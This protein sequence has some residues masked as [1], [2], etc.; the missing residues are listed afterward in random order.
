MGEIFKTLSQ[1]GNTTLSVAAA[2]LLVGTLF[3]FGPINMYIGNSSELWFPLSAVLPAIIIFSLLLFLVLVALG[4][5]LPVR[6]GRFFIALVFGLGIA[7]YIEGTFMPMDYGI[8]DGKAVEWGK[9]ADRVIIDSIIWSLCIVLPFL[10]AIFK[11]NLFKK[12]L[13]KVCIIVILMQ[14]VGIATFL[15]SMSKKA[16]SN[17][18]TDEKKFTL[19]KGENIVV[20]VLDCFD[21]RM[22]ERSIKKNGELADSFKDFTYYENSMSG[23]NYTKSAIPSLLTGIVYDNCIPFDEYINSAYEKMPLLK[24]LFNKGYDSR[25]F[26]Y[27]FEVPINNEKTN[28]FIANINYKIF[29]QNKISLANLMCQLTLMRQAPISLKKIF[30]L[31]YNA[32]EMAKSKKLNFSNYGKSMNA[33]LAFYKQLKQDGLTLIEG[34]AF[35]F[36]HFQG[37]HDFITMDSNLNMVKDVKNYDLARLDQAEGSLK[38][39]A[40]FLQHI[41]NAGVY[42][43]STIIIVGDHGTISDPT[44]AYHIAPIVMIKNKH[45]NFVSIKKSS[46]PV[47]NSDVAATIMDIIQ[48]G[49]NYDERSMYKI[50]ENANRMRRFY[51]YNG[52]ASAKKGYLPDM[53]EFI[54]KNQT[55]LPADFKKSGKI[56]SSKGVLNHKFNYYKIGEPIQSEDVTM[57]WDQKKSEKKIYGERALIGNKDYHSGDAFK[58]AGVYSTLGF[59][60]SEINRELPVTMVAASVFEKDD[61][62]RLFIE[63]NGTRLK[64]EFLFN[65]GNFEMIKFNIPK[66]L[67]KEDKILN[68]KLLTPDA[69]QIRNSFESMIYFEEALVIKLLVIGEAHPADKI[70]FGVQE[71][72][73]A[74]FYKGKGWYGNEEK[75]TW[76]SEKGELFLP[77]NPDKDATLDFQLV[78][79]HGQNYVNINI[80]GYDLGYWNEEIRGNSAWQY[81]KKMLLPQRFLAKDGMNKLVLTMPTALTRLG[82]SDTRVLGLPVMCITVIEKP[83][84]LPFNEGN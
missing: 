79:P 53:I 84:S 42:E 35:R 40:D 4:Y 2:A 66:E 50:D 76:S 55:V 39:T 22:F 56:L 6:L 36:Y 34:K 12:L 46:A 74:N 41:K 7:L 67:I 64:D 31:P 38:I 43:N 8:L 21:H 68:L 11:K 33:D 78:Y 83:G 1:R 16:T 37:A 61:P 28:K 23:C 47:M 24:M 13:P 18:L 52:Y 81:Y 82:S 62:Q 58:T 19:G 30:W 69:K 75:H 60:L 77:L 29:S 15:P 45:S 57:D 59:T 14:V 9:F 73:N 20:I 5:F 51:F 26:T 27:E 32:F 44:M 71:K 49:N 54:N 80:N 70:N 65:N 48:T 63:V 25:I 3:V 72:N 10:L 17:Y